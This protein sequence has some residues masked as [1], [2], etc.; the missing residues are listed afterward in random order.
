MNLSEKN[1]KIPTPEK[2]NEIKYYLQFQDSKMSIQCLSNFYLP[3]VSSSIKITK[4]DLEDQFQAT[5]NEMKEDSKNDLLLESGITDFWTLNSSY[6][7]LVISAEIVNIDNRGLQQE[8]KLNL[9]N[10]YGL[11][12]K[13]IALE[14]HILNIEHSSSSDKMDDNDVEVQ[15]IFMKQFK[16]YWSNSIAAKMNLSKIKVNKII[17]RYKL[18][19][20]RLKSKNWKSIRGANLA[21]DDHHMEQIKEYVEGM[22]KNP[23]KISM[24]K[25]A[26]WPKNSG[27]KP[28]WNSTISKVLKSKLKMSYKVL[29][30]WNTKRKDPQNQR[31][32]IESLYLQTKLRV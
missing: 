32:F 12:L 20:K 21:I 30:K 23:I 15:V 19:L 3:N 31:I 13:D 25:N 16:H 22:Y 11:N 10:W 4:R 28:P 26:V 29:H 2:K 24:I 18:L 17:A 7:N 14:I 5:D 8:I 6:K 1:D 27:A 9:E